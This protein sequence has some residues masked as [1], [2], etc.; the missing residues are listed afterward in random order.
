MNFA[1]GGWGWGGLGWASG[2]GYSKTPEGK[3]IAASLLDN[4]NKIVAQ[5]RNKP[6]LIRSTSAAAQQ[7]AANSIQATGGGAAAAKPVVQT[8]QLAQAGGGGALP[9]LMVGAFSGQYSGADSG[10][11][12][13]LVAADGRIS[14]VGQSSNGQSLSITGTA[15]ANG[16]MVMSGSGQAGAAQFTGVIDANSG[17]VVGTWRQ[18]KGQ[19]TFNGRKQ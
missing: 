19:G 5:V 16:S 10:V 2:G 18:G 8:T 4:F 1:L 15:N 14:G 7:N 13:V 12:S 3:L 9:T 17:S 6:Q 11:F